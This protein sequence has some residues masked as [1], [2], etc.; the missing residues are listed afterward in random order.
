M[1]IFHHSILPEG[2]FP[3]TLGY[4]VQLLLE[5]ND[6]NSNGTIRQI[7]RNTPLQGIRMTQIN[8]CFGVIMNMRKKCQ[9]L[10][11]SS[12]LCQFSWHFGPF[13]VCCNCIQIKPQF[14]Y[15]DKQEMKMS[16]IKVCVLVMTYYQLANLIQESTAHYTLPTHN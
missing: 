12:M 4:F 2:S 14:F 11:Q 1:A 8:Y 3:E 13:F 15:E 16:F 6:V 5:E 10:H 7:A 9:D